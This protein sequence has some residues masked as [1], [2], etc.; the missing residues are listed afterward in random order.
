MRYPTAKSQR[1]SSSNQLLDFIHVEL[2]IPVGEKDPT[3]S[4]L[5]SPRA[6]RRRT[7]VRIV[8][9]RPDAEF[10]HQPLR[11]LGC[12]ILA[13]IV[14]DDDFKLVGRTFVPPSTDTRR[15]LDVGLLVVARK[16]DC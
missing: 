12:A 3:A 8:M 15:T 6:P 9:H 13:A 16:E 7:Q 1:S 4:R 14:D 11:D 10:P 5:R 2:A